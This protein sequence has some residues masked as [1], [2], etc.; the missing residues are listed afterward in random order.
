[1]F[2]DSLWETIGLPAALFLV[3]IY[4]TWNIEAHYISKT[5]NTYEIRLDI[6]D[7]SNRK[8]KFYFCFVVWLNVDIDECQN[9][10]S[11]G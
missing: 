9:Q 4:S 8:I 7:S 2:L 10:V 1:M 5:F 3:R 11:I 6:H